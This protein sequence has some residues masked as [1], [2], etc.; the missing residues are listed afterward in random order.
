MFVLFLL[1]TLPHP[2]SPIHNHIK[3]SNKPWTFS[4]HT[5]SI[6]FHRKYLCMNME[7]SAQ[8]EKN[9]S[10]SSVHWNQKEKKKG[11]NRIHISLIKKVKKN[12]MLFVWSNCKRTKINLQNNCSIY[13]GHRTFPFFHSILQ[14]YL[15]KTA[16]T[17]IHVFLFP[18]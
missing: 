1:L 13:Y 4:H 18:Y 12:R 6:V 3:I 17:S 8:G 9:S 16:S 14:F 5:N 10:S 7:L 2:R 11:T 15:H